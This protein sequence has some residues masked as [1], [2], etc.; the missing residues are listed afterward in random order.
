MS[1]YREQ[2]H[3]QTIEKIDLTEM[4]LDFKVALKKLWWLVIL[5]TG[6]FATKAYFT[7]IRSYVPQ[8]IASATVLVQSSSGSSAADLAKIFPYILSSGVLQDVVAEDLGTAGIPGNINVTADEETNFLTISV[9]AYE[10]EMAYDIL[11]SVMENYPQVAEYVVGKTELMILDETGIPEDTGYEE[12]YRG[13]FMRGAAEGALLGGAILIIYALMRG[14]VKSKKKL[15]KHINLMDCGSVPYI[16]VKKRKKKSVHNSINLLNERISPG[17]V[18][19]IRKIRTKVLRE[20]EENELKSLL[21]TSSIP[22]EG[23]T[24]VAVNLAISIAQQGKKVVLIDCDM[25]N[26]SVAG[27]MNEGAGHPGLGA[28]LSKKIQIKDAVSKVEL[29]KGEMIVIY[30]GENDGANTKLLGTERM[31]SLIQ[32]WSKRADIVILDTAPSGLLADAPV[33]AKYVE[34]ALYIVRYDYTKLQQVREGVQSLAMSGIHIIGYVFNGDKSGGNKGYGYGY[35]Y[36]YGRYSKYSRYGKYNRY[37]TYGRY[38]G[39][40]ENEVD[41]DG[42]VFKD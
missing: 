18:E 24:T 10:P 11:E 38:H 7:V 23:K 37:G 36:G 34:A 16:P 41:A 29:P 19:A 35:S 5:L 30:G 1:E 17:Y 6:L 21:V 9:S 2:E 8:Y 3:N 40:N 39:G 28:I 14:T 26:P 32:Y 4:L 13:S 15:K 33:L 27:V 42:R 22:G 31:N 20:M 25:R 12:V